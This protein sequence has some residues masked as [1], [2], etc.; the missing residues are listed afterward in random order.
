MTLAIILLL[1]LFVMGAPIFAIM[2]G[3]AFRKLN[4]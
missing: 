1:V 3:G 4:L 2:L